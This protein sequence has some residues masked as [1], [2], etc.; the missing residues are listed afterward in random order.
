[1]DLKK[2][3][4]NRLGFFI[5]T[6]LLILVFGLANVLVADD[7]ISINDKIYSTQ[8]AKIG[9]A[10]YK[11]NCLICHDKKYF[12]PVFEA[13]ENQSLGTF[14]LVMS[15]SMPEDNPGSLSH[16]EFIDILAYIL[17]LNRYPSGKQKL[18]T[19]TDKLNLIAITPRKK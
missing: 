16:Q 6:C 1:M 3:L 14:F 17:K 9:E 8:Q 7:T 2:Q 13:W 5:Q 15:S 4:I 11:D 18:P 12:R 19:S 10:L